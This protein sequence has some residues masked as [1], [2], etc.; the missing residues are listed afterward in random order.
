VRDDQS[1]DVALRLVEGAE[2]K[3][4]DPEG[5]EAAREA[6]E[7]HLAQMPGLTTISNGS[8]VRPGFGF[9]FAGQREASRE[10]YLGRIAL[11]ALADTALIA[12][13]ILRGENAPGPIKQVYGFRRAVITMVQ[14]HAEETG[15]STDASASS[16]TPGDSPEANETAPRTSVPDPQEMRAAAALAHAEVL[17]EIGDQ[18]GSRLLLEQAVQAEHPGLTPVAQYRLGNVC[19][20]LGD[21]GAA[22]SAYESASCAQGEIAASA[23]Y[24]LGHLLRT[25]DPAAS[26]AAYSRA[27]A[28]E[29]LETGPKAAVNLGI[30]LF[31]EGSVD[32]ARTA[33]EW[34][35]KSGHPVQ[36]PKAMVNLAQLLVATG[37]TASAASLLDEAIDA[38][39]AGV[40]AQAL[41]IRGDLH[42]NADQS[43]EAFELYKRAFESEDPIFSAWASLRLGSICRQAGR[44][45]DARRLYE[46]AIEVGPPEVVSAARTELEALK[47]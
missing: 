39:V 14:Q 6:M 4:V 9:G 18:V 12:F 13:V 8:M 28:L 47:D 33:F 15:G 42:L 1:G 2:L 35:I 16:L 3:D 41:L 46:R 40:S 7:V 27:M 38:A 10:A 21:I 32:S 5:W 20:D 11:I 30:A 22:R 37:E 29:P 44:D 26:K 31:E 19:R 25:V 23:A 36:R 45:N 17:R 34:A 24:N 43:S